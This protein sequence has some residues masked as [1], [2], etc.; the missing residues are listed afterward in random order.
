MFWL[1][2]VPLA[3]LA[4]AALH[5]WRF[6][7]I[8]PVPPLP[9]EAVSAS[10][11]NDLLY[12]PARVGEEAF[13]LESLEPS[14]SYIDAR[15]DCADF[16]VNTLMRLALSHDLP[17][18]A[19]E[20][21]K[22]TL[23]G[24]KYW[25]DQGGADS[26]CYWSENHQI[27][28]AVNE[29]LAGSRW[30]G[31]RFADGRSGLEHA[32]GAKARVGAWMEQRFYHGFSEWYSNNYYPEDIAAMSNFIQFADDP[33]MVER[34]RMVLDLLWMDIATQRFRFV[35]GDGRVFYVFLSSSGRMYGDNKAGDDVGNR[36]RPFIDFVMQNDKPAL[37][38]E[39]RSPFFGAFRGLCES[40]RYR[41]PELIRRAMDDTRAR[42][43]RASSSLDIT[44][45]KS[46]GLIGPSDSQIMMQWCMEAFTAPEVICNTLAYIS[47]NH[48]FQ[49]AFLSGLKILGP[50]WLWK[51]G[52][53]AHVSRAMKSAADGAALERAN[54]YTYCTNR[55]FMATAMNYHPG[56][57]G[58][59]QQIF[60]ANLSNDLTVFTTHPAR[61]PGKGS[62]PSYWAG[63]GRNPYSV[64][65]ENVGMSIY[66]LPV[67]PGSLEP[68]V[69]PYTHA[70]FPVEF[71]DE[72]VEAHL[73]RGM[74]FGRK[75]KAYVAL[76]AG[77]PLAFAEFAP[78]AVTHSG[79]ARFH[80]N[81][82][83][84]HDLIQ[85]GGDVQYWVCELSCEEEDGSFDAFVARV[86]ENRV[87]FDGQTLRY[88]SRA[89]ALTATY[90]HAFLVDGQ[91]QRVGY[92]RYENA[93]CDNG[94]VK[95]KA[96]AVAFRFDDWVLR[97]D[98]QKRIRYTG[99]IPI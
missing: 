67:K 10:G 71:M 27:L 5:H 79:Q 2:L 57:F 88:E 24:F 73:S 70:Y 77:R 62:T 94:A 14:L 45:L 31:E 26:M 11:L 7:R 38:E 74:A 52:L 84:K 15:Y 78:G 1:W 44:E 21:V 64:Q 17:A 39:N 99:S 25:M 30:P 85:R 59:Q 40:G 92:E 22:R 18:A 42:V 83:Q 56:G 4:G 69:V 29:Y 65:H 13:V 6:L 34:M 55:Y 93:Y 82:T 61:F 96:G 23:T 46:E 98:Y 35:R 95:R 36:L 37:W 20:R 68:H 66:K 86:L 81:L 9:K 97:L 32:S 91:P 76:L 12:D 87:H 33:G 50:A 90:A 49:N 41:V 43:F 47:R 60:V 53:A 48:L 8:R 51:T 63:N 75:G 28:F 16:R 89:R 58:A 19:A 80:P 3:L 54:V 72:T